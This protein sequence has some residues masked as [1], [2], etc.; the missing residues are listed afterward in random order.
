[1]NI[2]QFFNLFLTEIQQTK[3]L[4]AYYR[5]LK[6]TGRFEFRK[7]YF[8]Q[9]LQ[10]IYDHINTE[11]SVIWDC[12]CGYGTTGIFL[13]MNGISSFGSTLE[14][15]FKDISERKNYW[16]Q[17]GNVDLFTVNYE[18]MFDNP[19]AGNSVDIILLQDTLHHLEPF[20]DA[21]T[22]FNNVLRPNG[23]LILIEENGNNIIQR[24]KLYLRRKN[25]MVITI[26]D[27]RLKK[28]ITIGNENIRSIETW[29]RE[30]SKQNFK[31]IDNETRYIRVFP[32]FMLK[33]ENA[34]HVIAREQK[35]WRKNE[36]IKEYFFFGLN[37]IVKKK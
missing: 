30:F 19:P 18:N 34:D 21:L 26:W 12:G 10:Y 6:S 4:Q 23:T 5:F 1:M 28:N 25:N 15:Y 9:R 16:K 27:E 35:L 11:K 24:F 33:S 14:F 36:L 3:S 8:L 2:N 20:Q 37:F 22:I 31:I 13:A 29:R 7:A 17:Y 32:P